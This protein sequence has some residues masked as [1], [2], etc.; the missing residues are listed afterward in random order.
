MILRGR[1]YLH[2]LIAA[3]EVQS[4]FLRD[5][6]AFLATTSGSIP[7]L[8]IMGPYSLF[9]QVQRLLNGFKK[10]SLEESGRLHS[11]MPL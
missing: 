4:P 6:D 1:L 2:K 10:Q 8:R 3:T 5:Q 11:K 7:L 9:F